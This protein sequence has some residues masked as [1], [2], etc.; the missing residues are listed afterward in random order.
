MERSG[1]LAL[2]GIPYFDFAQYRSGLREYK[3]FN[4]LLNQFKPDTEPK[5]G[6]S[7]SESSGNL[8]IV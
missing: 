8:R 4:T 1:Y 7:G 3:S 5:A 2:L 6:I